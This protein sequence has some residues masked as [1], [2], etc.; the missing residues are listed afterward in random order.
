MNSFCRALLAVIVV[1]ISA[2]ARAQVTSFQ[3]VILVV[4]ENR[5]PDNLFQA[6]CG[7]TGSLCPTPYNVQNFGLDSKGNAVPLV[8][9]TLGAAYDPDHGHA[10]FLRMCHLNTTTNQCAMNGLSSTY[11]SVG[12]C[13]FQYVD[14]AEVAPY[15]NLAQQYGWA[16]FMFQS[17]QGPSGPAHEFLF[18]GTSAPTSADDAAGRFVAENPRSTDSGGCLARL[19]AIYLV[20][21]P[22]TAPK[23]SQI[24]NTPLGSFCFSHQTLASLLDFHSPVLTWKYYNPGAKSI[25]TAPNWIQQICQPDSSYN[26]CTGPEWSNNLDMKPQ[27]V[28]VDIAACHLPNVSWVIPTGQISDHPGKGNT[29]GPSWV[30]SIVNQIGQ[31]PCIDTINGRAFSYWQDTAIV[32]TWDDWGGWYDHL[33]PT[34]LSK[35]NQGLGDYQYGFRVPMLFVSAYTPVG[36]VSNARLDFGSILRFVENNFNL[37]EGALGYADQRATDNL[38]EF[39]NFL[40]PSRLFQTISAPIGASFFIHD[41]RPMEPPDT[42]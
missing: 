13:S 11:C 17:N 2:T 24:V 38:A 7:V 34:L 28:L 22:S 21:S 25:W 18:A 35:P 41:T 29:G 15:T 26:Q 9:T 12:R 19:S 4:Q 40:L 23:E 42:D 32:I 30:A 36:F 6:L 1:G 27:D 10:A 33:P 16:N 37:G 31:S 39:Y 8:Q 3:H 14:A 5:T 20:I